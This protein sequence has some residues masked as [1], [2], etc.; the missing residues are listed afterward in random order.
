MTRSLRSLVLGSAT[1]LTLSIGVACYRVPP[2]TGPSPQSAPNADSGAGK[3]AKGDKGEKKPSGFKK[4]EDVLKDTRAIQGL[5]RFH[6]KRDNTLYLELAPD[7]LGLEFGLV[8]HYSRGVGDFNIHEGLPL[9]DAQLMRFQRAGDKIY[10]VHLNPRFTARSG[11][12]YERAAATNTG[13]SVVAAFE[14]KSEQKKTDHVL[15][16]VTKF[17]VSDYAGVSRQ[18]QS[19]YGGKAVSVDNARSY[20]GRVLG[21]PRNVELEAELT[22]RTSATPVNGGF[23]VSDYRSI[24]VGV[25][26]SLFALPDT[27][28][29][30]RLADDRVGHFLTARWDYSRDE[31]EDPYV[32]YVDRWRLEKAD[33]EAEISEPVKPIVYYVDPSV[34]ARYRPYV[35]QGI[36]AWNRAFEAAGFRHSIEARDPPAGDSTW[37]AEDVRYS[38]VRWTPSYNM[39][40]AIGP[41][42][43]DPR[44]G[45][46]LNADV[47]LSA[48]FVRSWLLDY[49]ETVGVKRLLDDYEAVRRLRRAMPP[50][51]ASYVCTAAAGKARELAL[52]YTLRVGLGELKVGEM[53]ERYVGDAVRDLVMHEI[54]HTLG[55]RHNF[56]ASASIPHDRLNDTTFTHRHGLTVSVMDYGPVNVSPDRGRQ[57]DYWNRTVGT[58]DI[59][60]IRYAYAPVK[61]APAAGEAGSA[62]APAPPAAPAAMDPERELPALRRIA[63]EGTDPFHSYGTDEDNWLGSF[64]VDPLTNAWDLGSDPLAF[65]RDRATLVAEVDPKLEERLIGPGEGY[66]RLR[67]ATTSLLFDRFTSLMPITKLVGG[68]YFARDHKG[69]PNQRPAFTPVPA[70]RQRA[71]VRFLIRQ[72]FATGSFRFSPERL[73]QLAPNRYSHW[74]TGFTSLPVDYPVHSSVLLIQ[75]ALLQELLAPPRLWRMIDNETRMP[76]GEAPYEASELFATL[77]AA[78]WSELGER[79]GAARPVDSFRRNL[80]RLHLEQLITLLLNRPTGFPTAAVPED[81]RS[82]ARRELTRISRRIGG[83]LRTGAPDAMTRAHLEESKARIDRALTASLELKAR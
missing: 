4:W 5:F 60:A 21:F 2:S 52:G 34:P 33:P 49:Q 32:R 61:T 41:S 50:G 38:T 1:A 12:A 57:G 20:V 64:A 3:G 35:K 39:G 67:G 55:L 79:G 13:H 9:S 65:A 26:Y 18:L 47:L 70:E 31:R 27:P 37:S 56:R 75:R 62:G 46:I 48:N 15:V 83:V 40:Y 28:M 23:G 71:A 63:A 43:T 10:L 30:P 53:P 11:S 77:T 25:R 36:E 59:W 8:M 29:T 68:L 7:Q 6:L 19:F 51:L 22:Y 14:I 80:Q 81:G 42:E 45:E 24:P 69:D 44:T 72:A 58:Y 78:I 73:N 54:G 76:Q 16:D 82:L 74:G 66:Q 17:L